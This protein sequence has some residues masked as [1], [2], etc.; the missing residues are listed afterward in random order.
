MADLS[1]MFNQ[2]GPAGGSILA[3]VQLGNEQNAAKSEQA[4]R[5][6][7]M[8]KILMETDQA[9]QMNPLL[10]QGKQQELK[11][12][13]LKAQ[14]DEHAY[15]TK[16]LGDIIPE[17]EK[18]PNGPGQ[19]LAYLQEYTIKRGV[20]LGEAEL[21]QFAQDPDLIKSLKSMHNWGI[22]QD[23]SYRQ[24]M[25]VAELN[26]KSAERVAAGNNAATR[27]SADSRAQLAKDRISADKSLS[28]D[29]SA[30]K[31]YQ[32]Q[33]VVYTNH[34]EK[35][36][37]AGDDSEYLRLTELAKQATAQDLQ[38][39]SAAGDARAAQ[40]LQLLQGLGVPLNNMPPAA[41]A[42]PAQPGSP[43]KPLSAY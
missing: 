25:D 28:Q 4:M 10:I 36:R 24:A 34:A 14:A 19:R 29:L 37:L 21:Q 16:V 9:K 31:N 33:S 8:D 15:H 35:A 20:P 39:K 38:A 3:G 11:S 2:L 18:V 22:T 13:D 6:A 42:V 26:R 1:T 12:A 27:Y 23:K 17:L 30:A 43:R 7:Q 41:P 32:A 40:Q 5:Q